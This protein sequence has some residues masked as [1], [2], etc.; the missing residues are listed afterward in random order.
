MQPS[1]NIF[2]MNKETLDRLVQVVT[3]FLTEREK[4]FNQL[5][6]KMNEDY[7]WFFRYR[8]VDQFILNL[9]IKHLR[10]LLEELKPENMDRVEETIDCNYHY[11]LQ[12]LVSDSV[13]ANTNVPMF[14]LAY[15]HERTVHQKMYGML[16]KLKR[17]IDNN[18]E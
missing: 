4:R 10:E 1:K 14:N 6:E 9:E 15:V 11:H 2:I 18:K 17:I 3:A 13:T 16:G 5:A 12:K 8:A 7:D